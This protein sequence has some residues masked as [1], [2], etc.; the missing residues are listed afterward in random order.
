MRSIVDTA[1]MEK[2]YK[3]LRAGRWSA[4]G[5]LYF[6]TF[7]TRDRRKL[8]S[9]PAIA[10][11]AARL[12]HETGQRLDGAAIAWVLMPDHWHG[13]IE[14]GSGISLSAYVG[15]LKGAVSRRLRLLHP[16]LPPVWQDGFHDHAIRRSETIE[17][18]AAYLLMNPIRA[19]LVADLSHYP[20]WYCARPVPNISMAAADPFADSSHRG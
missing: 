12:I 15:R 16:H 11:D 14:I 2:G 7:N 17:T 13:L 18:I 19:G 6:V 8:F 10:T 3:K 1:L 20:Y 9:D 5:H 4:N